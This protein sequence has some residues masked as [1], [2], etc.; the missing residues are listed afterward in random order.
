MSEK[1]PGEAC[2]R[3]WLRREPEGHFT[4][5]LE[6]PGTPRRVLGFVD[7]EGPTGG[8]GPSTFDTNGVIDQRLATAL[9]AALDGELAREA[10]L[11]DAIRTIRMYQK[12][13]VSAAR[14]QERAEKVEAALA[15]CTAERDRARACLGDF[16]SWVAEGRVPQIDA[17]LADEEVET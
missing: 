16:R 12:E 13:A 1:T 4:L 6:G 15:R 17:A 9:L 7:H 8:S 14:Y 5:L 3:F 2:V 11:A 10:D